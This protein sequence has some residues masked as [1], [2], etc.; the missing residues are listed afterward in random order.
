[1]FGIAFGDL[2]FWAHLAGYTFGGVVAA[3][4]ILIYEARK[5]P[6]QRQNEHPG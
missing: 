5:V 3:V 1:M 6:K 2:D 4:G